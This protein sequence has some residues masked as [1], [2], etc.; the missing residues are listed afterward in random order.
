LLSSTA[1]SEQELMLREAMRR[2]VADLATVLHDAA[3][4]ETAPMCA[5]VLRGTSLIAEEVVACNLQRN[6]ADH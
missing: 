6:A 2:A 1:S 3:G 5:A 4:V